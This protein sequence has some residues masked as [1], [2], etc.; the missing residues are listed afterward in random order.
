MKRYYSSTILFSIFFLG[1]I[2]QNGYAG[3]TFGSKE[4]ALRVSSGALLNVGSSA[5]SVDGTLEQ[6]LGASITGSD[7]V[8]DHGLFS[9]NGFDV[10]LTGTF[11]SLTE[12]FDMTDD[13]VFTFASGTSTWNTAL[14]FNNAINICL[15][16]PITFGSSG[17]LTFDGLSRINGHDKVIDLSAGGQITI[18]SGA[19]L[20]LENVIIKGLGTNT[21]GSTGRGKINFGSATSKLYL[22]NVTLS[23]DTNYAITS[24][25]V[26]VTYESTFIP[27]GKI[28]SFSDNGNLTINKS[29]LWLE[30][31]GKTAYPNIGYLR[32]GTAWNIYDSNGFNE[33]NSTAAIN[34]GLLTLQSNG[35]IKQTTAQE[36]LT[37]EEKALLSGNLAVNLTLNRDL[38]LTAVQN[39]SLNNNVT[40]DGGSSVITFAPSDNAQFLIGDGKTI[41]LKNITLSNIQANTFSFGINSHLSF[42]ANVVLE[43]ANDL[44]FTANTTGNNI[45]S[46][47]RVLDLAGGAPNTLTIR[48]RGVKRQLT[49]DHLSNVVQR[50]IDAGD[51]ILHLENIDLV[52]FDVNVFT[53]GVDTSPEYPAIELAG[54]AS[55]NIYGKKK[56]EAN[57]KEQPKTYLDLSVEGAGNTVKLL[58]DGINFGGS[59]IYGSMPVNE[60]HI[61]FDAQNLTTNRKTLLS[62]LSIKDGYPYFTLS[63][64]GIGLYSPIIEDSDPVAAVG[65]ARLI[66][67]NDNAA[68]E[69]A[70]ADAFQIDTGAELLYKNLQ[71]ISK[72]L[73]QNSANVIIGG[74]DSRLNGSVDTTGVRSF[75]K[76]N[77]INIK[78]RRQNHTKE[79]ECQRAIEIEQEKALLAIVDD[80]IKKDVV[81][82]NDDALYATRVLSLPA[83]GFDRSTIVN[84][85]ETFKSAFA[86][87]LNYDGSTINNF[88][89]FSGT[90][91]KIYNPFNLTLDSHNKVFLSN[92]DM[93][94]NREAKLGDSQ[95]INVRGTDNEIHINREFTIKNNLFLAA[96]AELTFVFDNNGSEIP[97]VILDAACLLELEKNSIVRFKGK[98]KVIVSNEV[99]VYFKGDPDATTNKVGSTNNKPRFILTDGAILDCTKK[100]TVN[101][102]GCGTIEVDNAAM[103]CPSTVCN[104]NIGAPQTYSSSAGYTPNTSIS[105][106]KL[107]DFDVIVKNNGEIRL[108][109]PAS[110]ASSLGAD[111]RFAARLGIQY[112]SV[113]VSFDLGGVLTVGNNAL[114]D[115]NADSRLSGDARFKL[116]R[117][118]LFSFCNGDLFVKAGGKISLAANMR[119]PITDVDPLSWINQQLRKNEEIPFSW[120]GSQ[121]RASGAGSVAYLDKKAANEFSGTFAPIKT[122][123]LS[124]VSSI[125]M[126]DLA[127][128]MIS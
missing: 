47:I 101:F 33:A 87:N 25:S 10:A 37:P 45:N 71:L 90:T 16:R 12:T 42:G 43:L 51:N 66:F 109:L 100:A 69:I 49:F 124:D 32:F 53:A 79:F 24:G 111:W 127:K 2:I 103:I 86:G 11:S 30:A 21:A 52:G 58:R 22:S 118:R 35:L 46:L 122:T 70:V 78:N 59:I 1:S 73:T 113:T 48:G 84:A 97:T 13:S 77:R 75:G 83:A 38:A 54:N 31:L 120:K 4:S 9:Q 89:T 119:S 61:N 123:L 19:T 5:L 20:Y 7:I 39:I 29:V 93:V 105:Y 60:L 40:I 34:A 68:V 6:A 108:D 55:I 125:K 41:T 67:D 128:N 85:Y 82:Q 44:I 27:N 72:S 126:I 14:S 62:N 110:L 8:F 80:I 95:I 104:I 64:T 76:R 98:G 26:F 94:L 57:V 107:D 15:T 74:K 81:D 92:V 102:G 63:G 115:I 117:V 65:T 91:T 17:H 18:A 36:G 88:L 121:I 56:N 106:Y 23:F 3:I 114:F 116:G 99:L 112:A 50:S 28:I 96:G